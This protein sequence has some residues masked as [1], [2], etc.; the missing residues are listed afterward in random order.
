MK[1]PPAIDFYRP[2]IALIVTPFPSTTI[3]FSR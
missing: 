3:I 1:T 2:K